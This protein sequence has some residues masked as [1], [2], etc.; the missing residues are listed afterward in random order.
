[1][2]DIYIIPDMENIE[3]SIALAEKYHARFEY[4]DFYKPSVLDD[5]QQIN[6]IITFYQGLDRDRCMDTL[7]GAF[8]DITVHSEDSLIRSASEKRVRQ[9]MDIADKLGIRGVIF[10]TNIISNFCAGE[11]RRNWI[12]SNERFW[13]SILSE[14]PRLFI[15]IENMFDEEPETLEALAEKMKDEERFGVCL[16]Y[17]HAQVFGREPEKWVK[18]LGAYVKHMHINDND[19]KGDLHQSVGSGSINWTHFTDSLE[20][21]E[22]ESTVLIE[23]KSLEKQ[24]ESLGYMEVN[25]IYPFK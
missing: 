11:Y 2:R 17:A 1:M 13:R 7:H 10:H 15:F 8:L 14:Y 3:E 24:R 23:T 20:V 21:A 16:D 18:S 25:K 19:L 6:E 4:N 5:E 9:C 22:V 12:E